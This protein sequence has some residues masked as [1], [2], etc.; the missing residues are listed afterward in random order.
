M[1]QRKDRSLRTRSA[2]EDRFLV[3]LPAVC[4]L[5]SEVVDLCMTVIAAKEGAATR[6][7]AAGFVWTRGLA[8][9]ILTALLLFPF[10]CPVLLHN[11]LARCFCF[12]LI[13][14]CLPT[15]YVPTHQCFGKSCS[16]APSFSP[17][18]RAR[19]VCVRAFFVVR[20]FSCVCSSIASTALTDQ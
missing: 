15:G 18:W 2:C 12:C 7:A 17:A 9:C 14:S 13:V 10:P 3:V 6:A 4:M 1:C 20:Y 5:A 8:P 16:S 11:V 19:C